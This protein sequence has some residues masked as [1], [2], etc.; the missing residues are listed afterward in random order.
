M[1]T[2]I[3]LGAG[4]SLPAK[5]P[6]TK[7]LTDLILSG[8]DVWRHSDTTYQTDPGDPPNK[9]T[10]LANSL[11]NLFWS[12]ASSY[13][14]TW[15]GRP[16]NY[17]DIYYLARQ[18]FDEKIGELDNPAIRE[19]SKRLRLTA[20]A[21][22]LLT[23]TCMKWV[24]ALNETCNYV[25]DIVWSQL[26][27]SASFT[28]HLKLIAKGCTSGRVTSISTLCHDTHVEKFLTNQDIPLADGFSE[29][30]NGVRYWEADLDSKN[31]IPF[32]KLHGS[33]NW[34]SFKPRIGSPF[35][36]IRIGIP[37]DGD[38]QHTKADDDTFQWATDGRP[39]LLIGTF[40]KISEY[41]QGI[42]RELHYRF[43]STISEADQLLIC[44]YSFGDKG[45][46]S[47]II[48]WFYSKQGRRFVIIHPDPTKLRGGARGAI[49][50]KWDDWSDKGSI[51]FIKEPLEKVTVDKFWDEISRG[52]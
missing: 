38:F 18:A 47:E 39:W 30:Q 26:C 37:L 11:V 34:F 36:D 35:F 14:E 50:N 52:Q 2:A 33:V 4:S 41:S 8:K 20:E 13:Y 17:E 25:A 23:P 27:G 24:E 7:N 22:K 32:L 10:K 40:N 48:E 43:R 51:T 12:E 49:S 9:E 1:K 28:D 15:V 16:P 5:F 45:I 29:P 46:N 42:F 31:K 44:G 6:S 3:L 19:F 21:S